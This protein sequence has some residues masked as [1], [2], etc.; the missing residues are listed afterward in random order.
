MNRFNPVPGRTYSLD[1]IIQCLDLR[2]SP[3]LG[4]THEG[5]QAVIQHSHCTNDDLLANKGLASSQWTYVRETHE[6]IPI[7]R[8]ARDQSLEGMVTIERALDFW[9]GEPDENEQ[10]H[11]YPTHLPLQQYFAEGVTPQGYLGAN[12]QGDQQ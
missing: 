7:F 9:T 10:W 8:L 1:Y 5:H 4:F 3:Y 12:E 11:V 6:W 2:D